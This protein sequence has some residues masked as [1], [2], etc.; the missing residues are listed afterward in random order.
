[1]RIISEYVRIIYFFVE[2]DFSSEATKEMRNK[3]WNEN[4]K[5]TLTK[6]ANQLERLTSEEFNS[7][8]LIA[9]QLK[10]FCEVEK[11][12]MGKLFPLL[13]YSLTGS[14]IGAGIPETFSVLGIE[15]SLNRLR[16]AGQ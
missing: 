7:P 2:P 14:Q 5:E 10:Q 15:T 4:S 12:K 8:E 16:V 6:I 11:L 3:V 13:R 9:E 1:M